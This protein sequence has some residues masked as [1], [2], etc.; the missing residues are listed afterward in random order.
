MS[1]QEQSAHAPYKLRRAL[2]VHISAQ[3][4]NFFAHT[5]WPSAQRNCNPPSTTA[6][7]P[8]AAAISPITIETLPSATET[9]PI[10]TKTLPMLIETPPIVIETLP[11]TSE[12]LPIV[13]ETPPII[14]ESPPNVV[15]TLRAVVITQF[16]AA[17]RL[18]APLQKLC[19]RLNVTAAPPSIRFADV[20][21]RA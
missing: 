8:S 17:T 16:P 6:T 13:I 5:P 3:R 4:T 18:R 7:P 2:Y 14:T 15:E 20:S 1:G 21:L 19:C 12:T 11:M 10:V 9:L